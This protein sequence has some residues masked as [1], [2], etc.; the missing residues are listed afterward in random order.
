MKLRKLEKVKILPF[1]KMFVIKADR[2]AMI[3]RVRSH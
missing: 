1:S 2:S 3:L